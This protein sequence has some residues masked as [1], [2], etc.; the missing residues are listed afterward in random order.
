MQRVRNL[1]QENKELQEAV[2]LRED[3]FRKSY[4]L[5]RAEIPVRRSAVVMED[6]YVA[7]EK[8]AR[9]LSR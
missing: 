5:W 8:T 4:C 7:Q 6:D 2:K 3:A 1:Q 9:I